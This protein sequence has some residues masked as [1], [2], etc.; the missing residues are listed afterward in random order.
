MENT[1]KLQAEVAD[2]D[3]NRHRKPVIICPGISSEV[4]KLTG[5]MAHGSWLL[6]IC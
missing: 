5:F 2:Q 1:L 6:A 4:E 3:R